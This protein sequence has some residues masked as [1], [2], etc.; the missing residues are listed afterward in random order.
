MGVSTRN[1]AAAAADDPPPASASKRTRTSLAA[2]SPAMTCP[3]SQLLLRVRQWTAG[4]PASGTQRSG[5]AEALP[6]HRDLPGGQR[7]LR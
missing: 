7:V 2:A 6:E 3:E 4:A 5:P 1:R